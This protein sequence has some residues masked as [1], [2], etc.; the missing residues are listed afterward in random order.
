MTVQNKNSKDV[1]RG[2]GV[3]TVFPFTFDCPEA[4]YLH[5]Y[6]GDGTAESE[7]TDN[8]VLDLVNKRITYPAEGEPLSSS[9]LLTI[10]RKLPLQQLMDLVEHGPFLAEDLEKAYD[11]LTMM[12]QQCAEALDRTLK[13]DLSMELSNLF[14]PWVPGK[15]FRISDDGQRLVT[16]EDP[17]YV[18]PLAQAALTQATAK[19]TAAANSANIASTKAGSASQSANNAADSAQSAAR[20][21]AEAQGY[22]GMLQCLIVSDGKLCCL[23]E[24][25]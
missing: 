9:K 13:L 2:N 19:A 1:Y 8:F 17:A 7:E 3:A 18:L 10:S 25:E 15:S 21:A 11:E 6:I 12:I 20:G 4:A 14:V 23:L 5:V 16:T 24:K 22:A